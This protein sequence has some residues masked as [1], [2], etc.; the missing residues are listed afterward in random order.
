MDDTIVVKVVP[1][2][3]GTQEYSAL[4]YLEKHCT[5][6]P[7]PKPLGMLELNGYFLMFISHLPG[8]SLDHIWPSLDWK[9]KIAISTQLD[10]IFS[11]LRSHKLPLGEVW[12]GIGGEGC[13]DRRR[14]IRQSTEEIR[15]PRDFR[16]FFFSNPKFGSSVW[17]AFLQKLYNVGK[18]DS[19]DQDCCVLT[20]GDLRLAN[21]I[22]QWEQGHDINIS[23]IVDWEYSG[24]YPAYWEAIKLTNCMGP[25]EEIDWFLHVPAV[26]SPQ[27][28]MKRWLLNLVWDRHVD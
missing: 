2:S 10:S 8:E 16:E 7:A 22:V 11:K 24:F 3:A 6:V 17:I 28:Y 13:I 20:H 12:G 25:H 4:G 19:E 14:D 27:R 26:I 9:Q 21:I 1:S 18:D 23:G 15:D 5:G